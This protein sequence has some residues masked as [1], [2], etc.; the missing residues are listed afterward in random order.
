[1]KYSRYVMF[2]SL[3]VNFIFLSAIY[4]LSNQLDEYK[5]AREHELPLPL[6]ICI[7]ALPFV[8]SAIVSLSNTIL[9]TL[10]E[11]LVQWE[12]HVNSTD[13]FKSHL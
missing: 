12:K 7:S 1:M 5:E 11:K 6:K 4:T 13:H 8:I 2:C 10:S 3:A 9:S